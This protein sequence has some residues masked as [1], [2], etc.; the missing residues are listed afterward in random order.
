MD[1]PGA[2]YEYAEEQDA[3]MLQEEEQ[4]LADPAPY[5]AQ[6]AAEVPAYDPMLAIEGGQDP[7][8]GAEAL[9]EASANELSAGENAASKFDEY[10]QNA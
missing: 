8:Y 7:F 5:E 6:V 2:L 9:N 10:I 1:D 3:A 4:M